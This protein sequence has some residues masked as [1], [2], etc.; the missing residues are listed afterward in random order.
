[1]NP[2]VNEHELDWEYVRESGRMVRRIGRSKHDRV[3]LVDVRYD[4]QEREIEK[5][6]FNDDGELL[7]RVT[8][9][10]DSERKP[11]LTLAYDK[12]GKLVWR[13]SRGER[14]E[15]LSGG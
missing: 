15:D 9:E 14:P 8:Y 10:W 4:Q 13:H 5:V 11:K 7:R 12:A 1:M 3:V 2:Q 6:H